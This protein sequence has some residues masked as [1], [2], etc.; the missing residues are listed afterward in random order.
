M[1]ELMVEVPGVTA[2]ELDEDTG[3][4]RIYG[5][6]ADAVKKARGFWEFMEDFIQVPRNLFEKVIGKNGKVIQEIVDKSGVVWVRIE[7][8][9]EN[10]QPR[11]DGSRTAENGTPADY[12]Q[13]RQIGSRSYSGRGGGRQGPNYASSDGTNSELSNPS[14][15]ESEHKHELSDWSLTGK[16]DGDS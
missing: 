10:K 9:N 1:A 5:E 2:I 3:T 8:D 15:I 4:F 7:G 14:E 6:S 13:L 12:E 16:D 11:E